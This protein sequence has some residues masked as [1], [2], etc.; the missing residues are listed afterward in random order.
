[1]RKKCRVL[2]QSAETPIQLGEEIER[3]KAKS[4]IEVVDLQRDV[5]GLQ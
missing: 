4:A 3:L 2:D 1:M 5:L